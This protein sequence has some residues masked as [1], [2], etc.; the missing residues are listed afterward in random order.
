MNVRLPALA[1]VAFAMLAFSGCAD[2]YE[3]NHNYYGDRN[4]G[5]GSNT[6]TGDGRNNSGGASSGGASGGSNT[7]VPPTTDP[8][9]SCSPVE[10]DVHLYSGGAS[11]DYIEGAAIE[12]TMA[13]TA[14]GLPAQIRGTACLPDQ[15]I[16]VTVDNH[17]DDY[18][19]ISIQP[20]GVDSRPIAVSPP[21]DYCL[22]PRGYQGYLLVI[23][24]RTYG[25]SIYVYPLSSNGR[26]QVGPWDTYHYRSDGNLIRDWG[27]G[28][29]YDDTSP[30]A[31]AA[32][33]P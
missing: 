23:P 15:Q 29:A 24:P 2:E 28:W 8:T 21:S 22:E 7:N 33:D 11:L 12:V 26:F 10:V 4:G 1:L 13:Y 16:V 9:P 27:S 19:R 31:C 6:N 18:S 14:S 20:R 3:T 5:S 30:G 25:Y 17:T 32:Y